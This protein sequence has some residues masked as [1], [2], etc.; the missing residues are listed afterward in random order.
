MPIIRRTTVV[1][2]A[3]LVAALVGLLFALAQG[4]PAKAS[5]T[6]VAKDEVETITWVKPTGPE[7]AF[8]A[9]ALD[10][11]KNVHVNIRQSTVIRVAKGTFGQLKTI[12]YAGQ[13]TGGPLEKGSARC[14]P[15]LP[16]NVA[17]IERLEQMEQEMDESSAYLVEV[18]GSEF[19]VP[20]AMLPHGV[21]ASGGPITSMIV[22][23]HTGFPKSEQ[24]GDHAVDMSEVS[25]VAT[26]E[27]KIEPTTA[28]KADIHELVPA[29]RRG[30]VVGRLVGRHV[31]GLRVD[32]YYT[33]KGKLVRTRQVTSA[34]NGDFTIEEVAA[35]NARIGARGCKT[36]AIT[37]KPGETA[38]IRLVCS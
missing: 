12:L 5:S 37:I 18:E 23:A 29:K 2:G 8:E 35:G 20:A 11:L 10:A 38:H 16:C 28:D 27:A 19:T 25:N 32:L 31:G 3:G 9:A 26:Y 1:T 34:H 33:I 22:D 15:G 21:A 30:R 13:E 6:E 4:S 24:V 36:G 7:M 14:F 17:E